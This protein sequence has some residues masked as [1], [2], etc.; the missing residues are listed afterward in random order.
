M[1]CSR[2][3]HIISIPVARDALVQQ[4]RSLGLSATIQLG[5]GLGFGLRLGFGEMAFKKKQL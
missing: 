4:V 2:R 1:S 5:L 3:V